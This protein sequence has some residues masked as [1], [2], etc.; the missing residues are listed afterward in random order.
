[1]WLVRRWLVNGMAVEEC[2]E[3]DN[4]SSRYKNRILEGNVE[5]MVVT[6]MQTR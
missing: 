3:E 4:F 6:S 5:N 2:E 1:M